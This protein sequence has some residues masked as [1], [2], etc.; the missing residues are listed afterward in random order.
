MSRKNRF[1]MDMQKRIA[2]EQHITIKQAR[3]KY[4]TRP[5]DMG[6]LD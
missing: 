1:E 4:V 3:K 2:G 5:K 6:F